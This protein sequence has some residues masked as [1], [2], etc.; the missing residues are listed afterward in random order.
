MDL[1]IVRHA[2]AQERR[3]GLSDA[4]RELTARGRRRMRRAADGLR[5][6]GLRFD[7]IEHSPLRRAAQTASLLGPLLREGGARR[8]CPELA[9]A[10]SPALLVA[11]SR[12]AE[13]DCV[14]VVGHE[15]WTAE[16]AAWLVLGKARPAAAFALRKGGVAWL[17]GKPEPGGMR[18]VA[19]LS[20]SVL[21]RLGRK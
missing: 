9:R 15:P 20:P 17:R 18:L 19:L 21:R 11:L 1:I 5:R 4:R 3:S 16:L 14:A 12:D 2:I 7:R 6:L 13:R 10:P 8:A